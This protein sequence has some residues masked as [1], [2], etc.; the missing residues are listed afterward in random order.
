MDNL[1]S[2]SA[3][4][5]LQQAPRALRKHAIGVFAKADKAGDEDWEDEADENGSIKPRPFWKLEER[6]AG[7]ASDY[8]DAQMRL[9][10]G[11]REVSLPLSIGAHAAGKR[12]TKL[13]RSKTHANRNGRKQAFYAL[14]MSSQLSIPLC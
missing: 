2:S 4:R 10:S 5:L 1:R 6:I 8:K 11:F 12:R 7:T 14:M 3:I 9:F 13:W